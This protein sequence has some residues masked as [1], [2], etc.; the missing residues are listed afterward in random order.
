ME[1]LEKL[2]A[3][4]PKYIASKLNIQ[5]RLQEEILTE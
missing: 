1:Q 3:G 5:L 2:T 4:Q